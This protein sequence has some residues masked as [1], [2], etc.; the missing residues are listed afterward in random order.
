[1]RVIKADTEGS[2]LEAVETLNQGGLIAYPTESSYALGVRFDDEA[3]L[4]KLYGLKG[5]AHGKAF[6]LIIP[7]QE[8]LDSIALDVNETARKLMQ[9]YWP[10]PLTL[11]LRAKANLPEYV[12]EK[13]TVAVRVPGESFALSLV[14]KAGFPITATSANLSSRPPACDA[15]AVIKYFGEDVDLVIDG[16]PSPGGLPSTLVDATGREIKII[17]AGA[18]RIK[19]S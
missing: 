19:P 16:G 1:M 7:G 18:A 3:E 13:G 9:E 12:T 8:A 11:V 2:V 14:R 5:R 17:R 4:L 10:G 6:P 15:H